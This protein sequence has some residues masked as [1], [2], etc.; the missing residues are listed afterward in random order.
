MRTSA[1][2][3]STWGG[4]I[5][6]TRSVDKEPLLEVDGLCK[7]YDRKKS[8]LGRLPLDR[9]SP[10]IARITNTIRQAYEQQG[11]VLRD[12]FDSGESHV[13]AVDGVSFS[14]ARG[15]I[16]GIVGESGC[17]KSTLAQTLGLLEEPTAGRFT[18]DGHS[19][20]YYQDGNLQ[21]F[22]QRLQVIFQ[23]PYE[24]LNPRLTVKQLVKEPL[25]IHDYRLGER[26]VG[27]AVNVAYLDEIDAQPHQR[28]G[29]LRRLLRRTQADPGS[30]G[31]DVTEDA[32]HFTL[33]SEHLLHATQR[34]RALDQRAGHL[35]SRP[36]QLTAS[37]AV[38]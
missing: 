8:L 6:G 21:S 28:V 36:R 18:F 13:R 25:T 4:A 37:C 14:V 23:N 7:W 10:S 9:G 12:V 11:D 29:Q 33:R 19:H 22:R 3:P 24:S 1:D 34:L 2:D 20:E 31:E 16:L 26:D 15:E 32:A 35:D 5:N 17:G 27:R 30:D 38:T